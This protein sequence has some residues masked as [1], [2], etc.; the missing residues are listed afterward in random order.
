LGRR[1]KTQIRAGIERGIAELR[2]CGTTHVG[3]ITN[4]WLSVE[5]LMSSGLQGIVYLEILGHRQERALA[6]LE[7][8]KR[9]IDQARRH[10]NYGQM[11]IGLS[12][13][14]P[15]SCHPDLLRAGAAWCRAEDVPLCIHAAESPAET[16]VLLT[17][18][19]PSVNRLVTF[20]VKLSGILPASVPGLRPIPY[21]ARL[22][23]LAARPLLA[24][25]VQVTAEDIDL[26][27]GAGCAVVHCPRSNNRLSCGRMP[28]E[29]YLA[30]GVPV[31][32]GTDSRA[33]SPD[34]DVRAE[35]EFARRLHRGLVE[36]QRVAK[37]AH[38]SFP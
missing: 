27:A 32:L 33:S 18:K 25:A 17:G 15:Y 19:L 21:L 2:A 6:R 26:I 11:Q 3:D 12:L 16:D 30:A 8:A 4:T 38:K 28:L 23:V 7:Q 13:H 20:L 5:P 1:S 36:P 37:L 24:H 35:A 9:E 29:R 14:A 31:Y 10:A 34:L 22:G